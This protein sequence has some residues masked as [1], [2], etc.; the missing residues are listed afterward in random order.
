MTFRHFLIASLLPAGFFVPL[1]AQCSDAGVCSI[2]G[3]HEPEGMFALSADY[4]FGTSGSPDNLRFHSVQVSARLAFPTIGRLSV[5]L[6][7]NSQ[8][9][10]LGS[11]SGI[12]DLTIV[13]SK[14]LLAL[15]PGDLDLQI[16]GKIALADVNAG[17]LPQAYQSG[18]GSN[19][20]LA[21][22]HVRLSGFNA[23][24]AWQAPF[25]R[26]KNA[27][28]RLKRGDDL[29][30]RA[31]YSYAAGPW[32]AGAE[33]LVLKRL[34]ES[35]VLDTTAPPE[36]F[37]LVPGSDQTQVNVVGRGSW[38]ISANVELTAMIAVPLLKRDINVDGLTRSLALSTGISLSL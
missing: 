8:S 29:L 32:T 19:D 1:H 2:G 7:F 12:G 36:T 33:F 11:V 24:V 37:R 35:S 22:L 17:G 31:G 9:G 10:P 15:G 3:S 21:G 34:Q 18:L 6:P 13:F 25:G 30:L 38:T 4:S 23:A 28:T 20:L 16:G 14:P 5:T 27:L 26:S